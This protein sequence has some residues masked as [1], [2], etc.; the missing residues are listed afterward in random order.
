MRKKISSNDDKIFNSIDII[1]EFYLMYAKSKATW[2]LVPASKYRSSRGNFGFMPWY[3]QL[4]S[5][6][7][8][9]FS[10][11]ETTNLFTLNPNSVD[12]IH[13]VESSRWIRTNA[14]YRV[15]KHTVAKTVDLSLEKLRIWYYPLNQSKTKQNIRLFFWWFQTQKPLV[16]L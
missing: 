10:K 4:K 2:S 15:H 12:Y 9:F 7:V 11:N 16:E 5:I 1:N 6:F 14:K 3:R 13:T 8:S